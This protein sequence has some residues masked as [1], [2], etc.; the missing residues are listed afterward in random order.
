MIKYKE[1]TDGDD[2]DVEE[3]EEEEEGSE[4]GEA[5]SKE[6]EQEKEKGKEKEKD[7]VAN[8]DDVSTAI[9][10]SH[11]EVHASHSLSY[12]DGARP[13]TFSPLLYSLS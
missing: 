2:S 4:D 10:L 8:I 6:K 3:E 13:L 11:L 9:D 12:W 5:E 7:I 1:K